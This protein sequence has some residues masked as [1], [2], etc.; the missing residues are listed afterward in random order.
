MML[1]KYIDIINLAESAREKLEQEPF[2][3]SRD[4]LAPVL[5]KNTLDYHY[6]KLAR[7]YV[8]RYNK[9]EGNDAFNYGGATLHNLYFPQLRPPRASNGPI[10][11]AK[12]IID[13]KW[14]SFDRFKEEFSLEF[15][16]A[17]G[18]NWI[19][20]DSKGAIKTIHN[21][22]Y[23]RSMDIVL[24]IDGWEHAWA[25]DYQHDKQKYLDNIW[26]IVDWTVVNTRLQGEKDD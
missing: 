2:G 12:E 17:Q 22:E 3:Y 18:S 6:G 23:N 20:M 7:G 10:G 15:M 13:S 25:L 24:I 5:S 14:G 21:H 4:E 1:K 19:Y 16:K 11:E 8:E 9:R 26:R